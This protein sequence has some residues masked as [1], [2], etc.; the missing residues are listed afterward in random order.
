[1]M[2]NLELVLKATE[3]NLVEQEMARKES[4][5]PKLVYLMKPFSR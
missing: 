1:M 5:E 4:P 2:E 3:A